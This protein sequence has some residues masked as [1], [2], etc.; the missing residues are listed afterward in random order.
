MKTCIGMLGLEESKDGKYVAHFPVY[1]IGNDAV[2][3][4]IAALTYQAELEVQNFQ[5]EEV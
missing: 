4:L 1:V 5:E 3:V 2:D